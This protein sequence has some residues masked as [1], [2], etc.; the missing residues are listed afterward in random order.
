MSK[1]INCTKQFALAANDSSFEHKFKEGL[2]QKRA[3]F[4]VQEMLDPPQDKP[5]LRRA[6]I[7][8]VKCLQ[9][10]PQRH[11]PDQ[12]I[13]QI[14]REVDSIPEEITPIKFA[15]RRVGLHRK[16]LTAI[17]AGAIL[18][19]SNKGGNVCEIAG[20][21]Y[22]SQLFDPV[23]QHA[24]WK[25]VY[26][27]LKSPCSIT[28][29]TWNER[30]QRRFLRTLEQNL[31]K[32]LA[33]SPEIGKELGV[34][35]AQTLQ[36]KHTGDG[37]PSLNRRIKRHLADRA[38]FASL[39]E[40]TGGTGY[41]TVSE[42]NLRKIGRQIKV[43]VT[44]KD[45][46]A[47]WW[48]IA[49]CAGLPLEILVDLSVSQSAERPKKVLAWIDLAAGQYVYVLDQLDK[50]GAL[51]QLGTEGLYHE[52]SNQVHV[53][54]P[55]FLLGF[56][57]SH[58]AHGEILREVIGQDPPASR[59]AISDLGAGRVSLRRLQETS[60]AR[61]L[62]Q[63]V[64]RWP[65]A[66][67]TGAMHLVSAGKKQYGVTRLSE[68]HAAVDCIHSLLGWAAPSRPKNTDGTLIGS[69]V[70]P[71]NEGLRRVFSYLATFADD[72]YEDAATASWSRINSVTVWLSAYMALCL[73]LRRSVVYEVNLSAL[74]SQFE[75]LVV[76]KDVHF[77]GD[78]TIPVVESLGK[79][80]ARWLKL[81]EG[82]GHKCAG[83]VAGP[84]LVDNSG[85]R[86]KVGSST[87]ITA[88]PKQLKLVGNFGRH[89]WPGE[90][91]RRHVSQ[92]L[93][94]R[95]MR[96]QMECVHPKSALIAAVSDQQIKALTTVMNE[97]LVDL[98]L[99]VPQ[100]LQA[101]ERLS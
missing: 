26:L 44:N 63:G 76:D 53:Q 1:L 91:S 30:S 86:M 37:E 34:E 81:L 5:H 4:Y 55:E 49:I 24:K 7:G 45:K 99:T 68:V 32:K 59:A 79:Y 80:A 14:E 60:I 61:G 88:L 70:T 73:A 33:S 62:Q 58:K 18:N 51:L 87:W 52:V 84:F 56:L 3:A 64:P 10:I 83:D 57:R 15:A 6:L 89:Y 8:L 71:T 67:A 25:K 9:S 2:T 20:Y 50:R 90:L 96:H 42:S 29:K 93:I 78:Q 19:S 100:L 65:L 72:Q 39:R 11:R 27:S 101:E 21:L 38:H 48:A 98:N 17:E 97:I 31:E 69:R 36:L 16:F 40:V 46:D 54:L 94:D 22:L 35:G 43:L 12:L 82:Q 95:L 41:G 74:S 47:V 23:T 13:R 85:N 66:L 28:A 92:E 77:L 75:V